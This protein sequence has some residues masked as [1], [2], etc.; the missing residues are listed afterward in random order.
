MSRPC[1]FFYLL[2]KPGG[3]LALKWG[4]SSEGEA[5]GC[6]GLEVLYA[7]GD[8]PLAWSTLIRCSSFHGALLR[9]GD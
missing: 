1:V 2:S 8:S 5:F 9:L 4:E 6:E 3:V 7:E